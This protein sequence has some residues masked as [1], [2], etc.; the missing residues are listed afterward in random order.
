MGIND[1]SIGTRL[2][3][4]FALMLFL[5]MAV[6][7]VALGQIDTLSRI[8]ERLYSHPFAV[9]TALRDMRGNTRVIDAAL[10]ELVP[11]VP[12]AAVE[13]RR[14]EILKSFEH[15]HEHFALAEERYLGGKED[16]VAVREAIQE[17]RGLVDQALASHREGR[18][19]EEQ[20]RSVTSARRYS[21]ECLQRIQVM[22]DFA[23]NRARL[24]LEEARREREDAILFMLVLLSLAV[25]AAGTV[26][27]FVTRGITV[28]LGEVVGRLKGVAAGDIGDPLSMTRRDE[29]GEL[30]RAFGLLRA[31][32]E[33]KIGVA[34][35]V[36]EGDLT[37]EAVPSSERDAL[38]Q[39]LDRMIRALR[40]ASQANALNDW[41]KTGRTELAALL[42]GEED[43]HAMAAR[44]VS[45]LARWLDAQ[46]GALYARG[47]GAFR[48]YGSYAFTPRGELPESFRP[49]E[50]LVGQA[51]LEGRILAVDRLPGDALRVNSALVDARPGSV[52]LVPMAHEGEVLAVLELGAFGEFDDAKLEFLE[53]VSG[54]V[55]QAFASM[56]N[57]RRLRVLLDET[58]AQAVRLQ[59]QQ[60]ELRSTNEELEQQANALRASEEEL[61][62]QQEELR[63]VNEELFEKNRFL[64][65]QK[66]EI[67]LKNVELDNIRVG[68]EQKARELERSGRYKSEFLANMSHELRTPLNSLLLLSRSLMD[69]PGGNLSAEQVEYARI[70]HRSGND[71]LGLINEILDLSRIEA[72][73]MDLDLEN[74]GPRD[75]AQNLRETF[76]ALA[77][78]KGLSLLVEVEEALPATVRTD[79]RRVE[80]ILRNLVSNAVKFTEQGGVTVR[81]ATRGEGSMAVSVADTGA[82]IPEDKH[83]AVF[84]AF[85]QL[86]GGT[87]RRHGGT[88]LGLTISRELA[89]LLG[90]EI[91]LESRSGEGATFTLVL[92]LEGPPSAGD[93]AGTARADQ[94][95]DAAASGVFSGADPVRDAAPRER[96]RTPPPAV[97]SDDRDVLRPG[98]PAVLIIEDDPDFAAVL[99]RLCRDRG[100]HALA[101]ATGED[102]LELARAKSPAA[103]V[104]DIRLPGMSGWEVLDAFKRDP[105]LRHIPVHVMSG[106]D[107]G[108]DAL[109]RG[110]VGFLP[111]PATRESLEEALGRLERVW[112]SDIKDL[113]LVEDDE[114]LRTAV[115][116]LIGDP[117][118]RIRQAGSGAQ[119]LQ[120][121]EQGRF[122]CM[123]L[124]LGLPDMTGFELLDRMKARCPAG[125]PPVIVYTGRELSREEE[126]RLREQADSIIVKGVRSEE[127]LIDETALFLHQVVRA[128]P[129][130]KREAILHL[131][132]KDAAFK[133]RTVLLV[134]D[135]MR[136]LFALAQVLQE[137]G[138]A[139][140]KAEDG[141]TALALLES[142]PRVDLV[143]MDIMMPG[144]DGYEAIRRIRAERRFQGLPV[145]ALTAK[146]MREDREK[147]LEAGASDYLSKPVDVDRLLSVMRV[148]LHK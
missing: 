134:D 124:D 146:A 78:E 14:S 18:P 15:L 79:P 101:A 132:E 70:I 44:V 59:V 41:H 131:Y 77:R 109:R 118:V 65:L 48:L 2:K 86:E 104:L 128:M 116:A 40:L 103:V 39:A 7:A 49:G 54:A 100:L 106:A 28:P 121:L 148:W 66:A 119:A 46:V 135:D 122:D 147:C 24:F 58:Q 56:E 91:L 99:A 130:R 43:A 95:G 139:V 125:P 45:F 138:L 67:S 27:A 38:G 129:Q 26:A 74:A 25:V 82:G 123:I 89:R 136:N 6:G 73:R 81:F 35:A 13:S 11:G 34:R 144:M 21:Q 36:A 12:P 42:V 53:S 64:E 3:V 96:P 57:Q 76:E 50:G 90:G 1:F 30:A 83:Q 47:D 88:G 140:L 112:T 105:A 63:A 110:A 19:R 97:I 98:V 71:L 62:Q 87:D 4:G 142:E 85:R 22:L 137:K 37:R 8:T 120:A 117:G 55:A 10:A 84:E 133:D 33:D 20:V 72:G 145:I 31:G 126:R 52:V 108:L 102:G 93:P 143:L 61:Q 29:M 80:Q 23:G 69:N 16:R 114:A 5:T 92:P 111:K 75:M 141:P 51:A 107:G 32:L 113:L 68:L 94:G 17:W 127:R 115:T 9:N 60:E